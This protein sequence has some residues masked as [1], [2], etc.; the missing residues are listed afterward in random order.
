MSFSS[1]VK[2][3]TTLA[4]QSEKK[5]HCGTLTYTKF[6]LVILFSSLLWGD[7]CFNLVQNVLP[8][9][10]PLKLKSLGT[11]NWLMAAIMQTMPVLLLPLHPWI[12]VK[13]DR[14]R[15][16]WGRRIPFIALALPFLS[17]SLITL[18]FSESISAWLGTHILIFH[19][20][21]PATLTIAVIALLYLVY[22][23]F[24]AFTNSAFYLVFNDVIPPQF[25]GRFWGMFRIFSALA[26]LTYNWFV[27][28][29]LESNMREVLL[30]AAVLY[31]IGLG[32]MCLFVK[33]GKYPPIETEMGKANGS[34]EAVKIFLKE[35]FSQKFYLAIFGF[36]VF[37]ALGAAVNMFGIFFTKD[38]MGLSMEQLGKMGA[39]GQISTLLAIAVTATFI[40]RWHPLRVSAYAAIFGIIHTFMPWVWIF[41]SLPTQI[42]FYLFSAWIII[43]QF[44]GA[45]GSAAGMPLYMRVFP[46]SR[47]GQFCSAQGLLTTLVS[48]GAVILGGAFIDLLGRF[49]IQPN[50][51][52][53][54]LWVWQLVFGIPATICIIYAYRTWHRMGGDANFHPPAPWAKS[55]KEEMPIVTTI[56]P[57][58]RWLN[59][60][61]NIFTA[62]MTLTVTG[63]IFFT[64]WMHLKGAMTA[65]WWLA[66]VLLP[67]SI[68]AWLCWAFVA[69][70]IRRDIERVRRNETPRNGI[71]HHGVLII[72]GTKFL[73]AVG[74]WVFEATVSSRLNE[75]L[76]VVIFTLAFIIVCFALIAAVYSIIR[77]ERGF[78]ATID[79]KLA[80][81]TG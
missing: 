37:G 8:V 19:S 79:Q 22:M 75:Q 2:H 81:S 44:Q 12:S 24:G 27:F 54:F 57:S 43:S 61:L 36:T 78:S 53:R 4:T 11:E 59:I 68:L 25:I 71:P 20:I 49:F 51:E 31:F 72:A 47:F 45:I 69:R 32:A 66:F 50:F 76:D 58:S 30:G 6:G 80:E 42:I 52:Y 35:S 46:K 73:A 16:K 60:A 14:C 10:L 21:A 18:A 62:I 48:A 40:D 65:F 63:V 33:E 9:A 28:K 29:Y 56:G 15:S 77:M 13:S 41:V 39:W 64:C 34:V 23:F 38:C 26:G 1:Q 5:F 55:G 17:A 70:G 67:L 74:I 7:F 3:G